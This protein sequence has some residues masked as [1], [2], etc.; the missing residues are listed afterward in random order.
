VNQFLKY[1]LW[2]GV[3]LIILTHPTIVSYVFHQLGVFA[4][5]MKQGGY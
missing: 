1:A 5:T 4:A 3:A 2:I